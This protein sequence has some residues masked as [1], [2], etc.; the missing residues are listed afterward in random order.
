MEV[1]VIQTGCG[2]IVVKS[3]NVS[4]KKVTIIYY[5]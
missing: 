3:E 2:V 4:K 1:E 5:G